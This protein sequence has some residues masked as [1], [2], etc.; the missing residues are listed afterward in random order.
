[1]AHTAKL[2]SAGLPQCGDCY[3]DVLGAKRQ[4]LGSRVQ[5]DASHEIVTQ[6]GG[7]MIDAAEIVGVDRR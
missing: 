2:L 1:M 5:Y 6:P 7:Q 3:G 4:R